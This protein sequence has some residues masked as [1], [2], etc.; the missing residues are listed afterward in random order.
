MLIRFLCA[1]S[2]LAAAASPSWAKKKAPPAPA[3]ISK[4]GIDYVVD[5]KEPTKVSAIDGQSRGLPSADPP[6]LQLPSPKDDSDEPE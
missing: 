4:A 3:P 1:A 6:P 5:R 2:I